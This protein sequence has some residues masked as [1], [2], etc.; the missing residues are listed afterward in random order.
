MVPHK[1]VARPYSFL[2]YLA[3]QNRQYFDALQPTLFHRSPNFV[4]FLMLTL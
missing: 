2:P 4:R 1:F 3:D